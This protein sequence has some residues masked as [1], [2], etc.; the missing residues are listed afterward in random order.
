MTKPTFKTIKT[1]VPASFKYKA[2]DEDGSIWIYTH[3]PKCFLFHWE[4][5]SAW[6]NEKGDNLKIGKCPKPKAIICNLTGRLYDP[7]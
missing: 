2:I 1:I 5:E 6:F 3:K 4:D 7:S